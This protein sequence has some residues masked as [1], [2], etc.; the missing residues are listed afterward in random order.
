[1]DSPRSLE[2]CIYNGI[3]PQDLVKKSKEEIKRKF[4]EKGDII[5]PEAL[6]MFEKNFEKRR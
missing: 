5:T 3:E 6:E 1:M 4:Q 2:I